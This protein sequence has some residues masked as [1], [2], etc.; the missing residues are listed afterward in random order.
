MGKIKLLM[1]VWPLS[2][3]VMAA[4]QEPVTLDR[5]V[6]IVNE[7]VVLQSEYDRELALLEQR[8]QQLSSEQRP[9]D[10]EVRDQ[11]LERLLVNSL[12]YQLGE[13][14]G[15]QVGDAEINA[16]LDELAKEANLSTDQYVDGYRKLGW[17]YLNLREQL[18]QQLV[19]ET[20]QRNIIYSLVRVS[21]QEISDYLNSP[22]GI[23]RVGPEY[24]LVHLRVADQQQ[25]E[26]LRERLQNGESAEQLATET[27][28]SNWDL[29]WKKVNLLPSL[30]VN[31]APKLDLEEVS[32]L[33]E[34]NSGYH[35]IKLEGRRGSAEKWEEQVRVRHILLS[36]NT[37]RSLDQAKAKADE[38]YT[39]IKEGEDMA[40]MARQHSD[41][42][43][44]VLAGGILEW[45]T[46]DAYAP[47]FQATVLAATKGEINPPVQTQFGWHLVRLE[48][49]RVEDVSQQ[50]REQYAVNALFSRR[51]AE[52]L[53]GWL[54]D[55]R[56]SA[57]VK[58][59]VSVSE[60]SDP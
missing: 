7:S 59:L 1:F 56:S 42:P 17:T 27:G 60:P 51:Y 29:G 33:I 50:Q 26:Q 13:S 5:I 44:S 48:D 3:A 10:T 52:A 2:F 6:A 36:P 24:H 31:A 21:D 39:M 55:L 41:D 4:E 18:R 46:P 28:Q 53:E 37:I 40:E 14:N 9:A 47:E 19:V 57:F 58:I 43:G 38:L 15:I 49:T 35:I 23:A 30:F 54:R 45:S 8:L 34:S 20:L 25:A 32:G 11:A 16:R 22:E 12:Q